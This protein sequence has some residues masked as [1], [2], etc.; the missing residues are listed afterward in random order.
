MHPFTT[1]KFGAT[2]LPVASLELRQ[3]F[4]VRFQ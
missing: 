1:R 3:R 2:V 4:S